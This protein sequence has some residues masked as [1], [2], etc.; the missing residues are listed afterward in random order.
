MTEQNVATIERNKPPIIVLRERLDAR[1]DELRK[2]LPSDI[3][4]ERF[5]RTVVTAATINPDLQ[6][7]SWQSVW[8]A[9]M[10][11]CQDGLLPDGRQGAIVPYKDRASWVPMYQGVIERAYRSGQVKWIG[12]DVVREGDQWEYWT[13]ANG[14]HFRHIPGDDINAPVLRAYAA[15]TLILGGTSIAVLPLA[16]LNKIRAVSKTRREDSPW[17]IWPSEMQKKTAIKRLAKML[18]FEVRVTDEGDDEPSELQATAPPIAIMGNRPVGVAAALD[19]FAGTDEQEQATTEKATPSDSAPRTSSAGLSDVEQDASPASSPAAK[20]DPE[21]IDR[22]SP[23]AASTSSA[24]P[25]NFEQY[26][27]LVEATCAAAR[28]ADEL[29]RWFASDAQ[30]R[31]RNACGLVAEDT[32]QCRGIVTTRVEQLSSK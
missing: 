26:V 24:A 1:V 6:A 2:A 32:A 25:K 28:D 21:T 27:A 23:A 17:N 10:R 22:S 3:D 8:T 15:A 16:E 29:K 11:A 19:A 18:P 30:R 13:D 20:V 5:I 9:C 31:L 4:P 7:C 14:V 12:A